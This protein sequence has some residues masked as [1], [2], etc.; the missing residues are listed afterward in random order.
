MQY[1]GERL[2]GSTVVDWHRCRASG[3]GAV[4]TDAG[5][6]DESTSDGRKPRG[7]RFH[8]RG[9]P[10]MDGDLA[11]NLGSRPPRSSGTPSPAPLIKRWLSHRRQS[12][13][14]RVLRVWPSGRVS[15]VAGGVQS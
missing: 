2:C 4:V 7:A 6:G 9:S 12:K 15:V 14:N 3:R 11:T 1:R 5:L 10:P 8:D 13:G